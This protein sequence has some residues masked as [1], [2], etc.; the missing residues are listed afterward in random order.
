MIYCH[1]RMYLPP[2]AASC[3]IVPQ[4]SCKLAKPSLSYRKSPSPIIAIVDFST[5]PQRRP[6]R[7]QSRRHHLPRWKGNPSAPTLIYPAGVDH[8]DLNVLIEVQNVGPSSLDVG[9]SA[10]V[11]SADREH[12]ISEDCKLPIFGIHLILR[13][14]LSLDRLRPTSLFDVLGSQKVRMRREE[15]SILF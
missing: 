13:R 4:S 7:L 6:R 15:T 12:P 14:V 8:E 5:P 9:V 10:R 1:P 2:A 3:S 11:Y